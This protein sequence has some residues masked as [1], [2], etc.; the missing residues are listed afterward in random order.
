MTI[1]SSL[2]Q[3]VKQKRVNTWRLSHH[4]H[5]DHVW[6]LKYFPLFSKRPILTYKLN[7]AHYSLTWTLTLPSKCLCFL[8]PRNNI[9]MRLNNVIKSSNFFATMVSLCLKRKKKIKSGENRNLELMGSRVPLW[10]TLPWE[11]AHGHWGGTNNAN[12]L[13]LQIRHQIQ[14]RGVIEAVVAVGKYHVHDSLGGSV[15]H[16]PESQHCYASQER[17]KERK[18]DDSN[19]S[20]TWCMVLLH[21]WVGLSLCNPKTSITRIKGSLKTIASF[22]RWAPWTGVDKPAATHL[23]KRQAPRFP[24]GWMIISNSLGYPTM[25]EWAIGGRVHGKSSA[26]KVTHSSPTSALGGLSLEFPWDP[27]KALDLSHPLCKSTIVS[28]D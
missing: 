11:Q 9:I 21:Y 16:V 12:T 5:N 25:I 6:E 26:R 4:I 2:E 10:V 14:Q 23:P 1:E 18:K 28:F 24:H 19:V 13:F 20:T 3:S 27:D 8:V 7:I 15:Q 17:K 22:Q